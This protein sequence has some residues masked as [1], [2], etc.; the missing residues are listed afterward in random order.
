MLQNS[1]FLQLILQ[2]L[3]RASRGLKYRTRTMRTVSGTLQTAFNC[4]SQHVMTILTVLDST[5][6]SVRESATSVG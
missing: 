1:S 3:Q 5:G 6:F 4:A 2:E